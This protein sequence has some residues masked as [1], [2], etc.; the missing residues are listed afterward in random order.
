MF[1]N[2]EIRVRI[3]K[4]ADTDTPEEERQPLRMTK[5]EIALAK[6]FAKTTALFIGGVWVTGKLIDAAC[7]IIVHKATKE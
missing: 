5:D 4:R 6:D 1:K 7:S 2:R 3:A